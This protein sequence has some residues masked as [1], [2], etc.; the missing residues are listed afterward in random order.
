MQHPKVEAPD[1]YQTLYLYKVDV[2]HPVEKY[3]EVFHKEARD[4][5]INEY[6]LSATYESWNWDDELFIPEEYLP[7]VR[8]EAC[9]EMTAQEFSKWRDYQRMTTEKA[10]HPKLLDIEAALRIEEAKKR[11]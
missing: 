10:I 9:K 3:A 8:I 6:G 2:P 4:E 7:E 11:R 5:A 1:G